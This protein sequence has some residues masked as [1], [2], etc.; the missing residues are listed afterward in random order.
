MLRI[1]VAKSCYLILNGQHWDVYY[2]SDFGFKMETML[3]WNEVKLYSN[4]QLSSLSETKYKKINANRGPYK[5]LPSEKSKEILKRRLRYEY[6]L[7][8]FIK[9]RFD[10]LYKQFQSKWIELF[11]PNSR[12]DFTEQIDAVRQSLCELNHKS[13]QISVS[14]KS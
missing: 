7:Y 11:I 2:V 9:A 6:D 12:H 3:I 10:R 8:Y 5:H 14:V 13:Y 4:L 1:N